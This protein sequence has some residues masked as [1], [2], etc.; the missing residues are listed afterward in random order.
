MDPTGAAKPT[1]THMDTDTDKSN[2]NGIWK[3]L[4]GLGALCVLAL[5]SSAFGFLKSSVGR[6]EMQQYVREHSPYVME[7]ALIMD[8]MKRKQASDELDRVQINNLN[9][10]VIRL[11]EQINY[12]REDLRKDKER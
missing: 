7:R 2:G 3:W 12:L 9:N 11:T 4:A 10:S 8:Y 5:A 6:D 1:P